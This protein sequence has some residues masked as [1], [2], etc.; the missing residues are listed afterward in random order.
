M[1]R[2]FSLA[3]ALL[4]LVT[5]SPAWGD[6]AAPAE[7]VSK[8]Q[9]APAAER[10]VEQIAEQVRESVVVITHAGRDGNRSGLGTGFVVS[11][12]GLIATNLHVIG[13]SRPIS[14][15]MADGS[16]KEVISIHATERALDLAIIR[17]AAADLPALELGDSDNV[18]QGE[19]VVAVGNPHGL[20]HSVVSGVVSG[21][22]NIDGAPMLQLAI[23]VE[24]GN[25]GGPV[26]DRQ[27]R[28]QGIIT[29][30]SAVTEN[31]GFAVAI[32]ALEPL[33]KRPNPMAISRWLNLGALD[34]SEW[35]TLFG[36]RW[37]QRAGRIMVDGAGKGFGGRSLS[38]SSIDV[39]DD[40][41][42]VAV[43]V[44]QKQADGAAGLVF[45]ANG[46]H[47]H[48][49]FYPSN[50]S[51]RLSRFDGPN[52]YGWQVLEE[53]KS[54]SYRPDDWNRLKVRVGRDK[55]E[56]FLN[57]ELVIT[58]TDAV[59][60]GGQVGLAKFRH[61]EAEFRNF[62]IAPE[63]P[64]ELPTQQRA[65]RITERVAD[66]ATD[67]P[68]RTELID[69]LLS[70]GDAGGQLLRQR[71][72]RL[73][74]QAE[75]LRQ[76]ADGVHQKRV[77]TVLATLAENGGDEDI[78]LLRGALLIARL[79]DREV[80]VDAYLCEVDQLAIELQEAFDPDADQAARLAA[81]NQYLFEELGFHGSRMDYYN[82]A[83][84]YL[85]D[86]IDDREG[87]PIT[88]SVLYMELARR[89]DLSIV[90]VGLPGH[91]VVR[92]EPEDG[93]HQIIDPFDRGQFVEREDAIK[94]V[95]AATRQPFRNEYFDSQSNQAIL[96]RMLRNLT[97]IAREARDPESMLRYVNAVLAIDKDSGGDRWLRAVLNYNTSRIEEA[98]A[99]TQQL[100]ETPT[101][102]VDQV[103][104]ERL[105]QILEE[106]LA[107]ARGV[108]R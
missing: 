38:L 76:L 5:S 53:I 49:G 81:L 83:N 71:A 14:V 17:I 11:S 30:K 37:R 4:W 6:E 101:P 3:A 88:L 10:T 23:P 85:N 68:P 63:I 7:D 104:V 79:D 64:S 43:S 73:E 95:E 25:S 8:T 61:T 94:K 87:L 52:V 18:Q 65:Q 77:L 55:I 91:F 69:E 106:T 19:S 108:A 62:R 102:V 80:D 60:R 12:D 107:G 28:V 33:L 27:G 35:T 34:E 51:L 98:L 93:E 2:S 56:C 97:G 31:L 92:H 70:D 84:S 36:A 72:R 47:K 50:G 42:E 40:V 16:K 90:G 105:H 59:Y 74:A 58:S 82:K 32:N 15:Q 57:D 89:I 45:H 26:L 100:L 39:P 20:T 46:E 13:E 96:I 48:Y 86:V 54:A 21:K 75:R 44:K 29:L 9:A 41:F 1:V 66:I 22:R 103:D 24:S 78:D 99:D 67:R